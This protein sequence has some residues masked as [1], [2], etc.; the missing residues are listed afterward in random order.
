MLDMK[1]SNLCFYLSDHGFGHISRNLPIIAEAARRTDGLLYLV[2]GARH[3]DFTKANLQK[4]LSPHQLASIRYRTEHTDVGLILQSGTLL[5]D[6]PALT[7]ACQAYLDQLPQRAA[8]E[9]DWLRR[10]QIGTALCDMPLWS[11]SA[12]EQAG[13]PLLYLGN[14]TWTE[15]YREFL[16]EAIWKAYA[17]HYT[18]IRHGM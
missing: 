10:H 8:E 16:P 1:A 14:F 17:A 2:C 18:K 13:V 6:V 4:M 15:L 3:L 7:Q 5:V 11:I 9:A 12:C